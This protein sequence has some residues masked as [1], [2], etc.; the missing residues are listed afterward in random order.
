MNDIEKLWQEYAVDKSLELKERLIIHYAPL[1]KLLAGR[2]LVHVHFQVDLDDMV[3]QGVFGLIDAI[4]KFDYAKGVKFETYASLRIRGA[5]IDHI[6]YMDWVPRSQRQ[7]NKQMLEIRAQL[8]EKLGRE[9]TVEEIAEKL[10]LSIAETNELIQ[11]SAVLSLIS[12]DDYLEDNHEREG[13]YNPF[14]SPEGSFERQELQGILAKAIE[15]L[16]ERERLVVTL[17]YY[18]Q[19]TV[20]EIARVMDVTSAR[21]SQLHNAALRKLQTVLGKQEYLLFN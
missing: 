6:R 15:K 12:L 20:T 4:D 13:I 7:K 18:E 19:L 21:V 3:G 9:P 5:I 10:S 16:T 11:K 1:V 8:E 17:F 2:L 14:A